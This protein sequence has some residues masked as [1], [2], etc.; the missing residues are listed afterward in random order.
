MKNLKVNILTVF[1]IIILMVFSNSLSAADKKAPELP[2]IQEQTPFHETPAAIPGLIEAQDFDLG[3]EGEAYHDSDT[4]NNGN[5][6]RLDTDVDIEPS[7]EHDFN[8]GW[9]QPGEWVEYTVNVESDGIYQLEARVAAQNMDGYFHFEFD[10]KNVTGKITAKQTNGW[11]TW[12]TVT[13]PQFTLSAGVQIMKFVAESA[14]FNI[15][16]MDIKRI[17]DTI[18][19]KVSITVPGDGDKFK[20]NESITITAEATDEDGQIVNVAF[21]ANENKIGEKNT[22]PYT[23]N[24]ENAQRGAYKLSAVARDNDGA[25]TISDSVNIKVTWPDFA[26]GPVFSHKRGF[27]DES[28]NL[29]VST[30]IS[31]SQIKYTLDGSDPLT[32][33]TALARTSPVTIK[34]D[35]SSDTGRAKTPAVIVQAVVTQNGMQVTEVISHT[36]IFLNKV[37]T[38]SWPGGNWPEG[39]LNGQELYYD[40]SSNVVNDPRYK[41]DMINALKSLPSFSL[42]TDNKNLFDQQTGI[43]VNALYHG[44]DWEKPVSVELITPDS[45]SGFQINAGLRIRGGWSRHGEN[46]KHAFRLFFREE[47]YGKA[48]LK[49]PLFGDEGVDEFDKMDLRTS[50]NYSW[51]Y[52]GDNDG[53]L[54]IMNRDVFSRDVQKEMGHPYTRSRYCHLYLNGMY[55]GLFQTQER[56]EASFAASYMGGNREDYDVVKVNISDDFGEGSYDIEAT[57]GNLDAWG[58]IYD[59]C[60]AGFTTN[61]GYFQIQGRKPDGTKDPRGKVLVDIDNLVDYMLIIFYTGNFDAP[62]TKFRQNKSPNNFYAIYD[63]SGTGL[64]LRI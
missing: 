60:Q 64:I 21:F 7:S 22:S 34:I 11:Q 28:F 45:D 27:Y 59:M 31:T 17:I 6:Y 43:Y 30:D 42:V 23:V 8:I 14:E 51:S 40:M 1:F 33:A 47:E 39:N 3:S 9:T 12:T 48:K 53:Y 2:R 44:M 16:Y 57:D 13:S 15:N 62:C 4:G 25:V 49:Y 36:Y 5:A 32:S 50:Q 26:D 20:E 10:G 56:P 46:P 19:P 35:P 24:W 52:Y 29:T 38:Q 58:E 54:N 37:L 55:W 18:P 61:S 63:R 41:N